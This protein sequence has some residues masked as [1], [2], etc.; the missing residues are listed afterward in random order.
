MCCKSC[1]FC[2]RVFT[3]GRYKYQLWLS[4]SKNKVCERCFLCRSLEFCKS[5]HKCPNCC[6]RSSSRGKVAPVLGV[7][8]SLRGQPQGGNSTQSGLHPPLP[9]QTQLDQVTNCHKLLYKPPQESILAG[10]IVSASDQKCSRTG[11]N[12]KIPG[13]LQKGIFSTKTQQPVET[14][15]GPE[16]LEQLSKHRVVPHGHTRDNKNLPTGRVVG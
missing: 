8:G 14:Y 16:H 6:S 3:K 10:G 9:V 15:L 12:S 7:V 1:S 4:L 2:Q 11:S 5:C 13:L